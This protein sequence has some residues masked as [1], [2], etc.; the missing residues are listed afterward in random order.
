MRDKR[1]GKFLIIVGIIVAV[2]PLIIIS[3]L[4]YFM[5]LYALGFLGN[6]GSY[7]F[8]VAGIIIAVVGEYLRR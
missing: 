2:V 4:A 3:S 7:M 1:I 5:N 8:L 6:I